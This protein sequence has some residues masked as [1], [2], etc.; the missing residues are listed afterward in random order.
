MNLTTE[1][2]EVTRNNKFVDCTLW[3]LF[4]VSVTCAGIIFIHLM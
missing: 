3:A 1:N 2:E 4:I